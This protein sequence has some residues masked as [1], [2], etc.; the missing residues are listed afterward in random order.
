MGYSATCYSSTTINLDT[1][2]VRH[3]VA[4][5]GLYIYDA[6]LSRVPSKKSLQAGRFRSK[7]SL[8]S[9][10]YE[11]FKNMFSNCR[12]QVLQAAMHTKFCERFLTD[13]LS[14]RKK[15]YYVLVKMYFCLDSVAVEKYSTNDFIK[16][17]SI[18]SAYK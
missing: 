7:V 18:V 2:R 17:R 11:Q 14:K 16:C 5:E 10:W 6:A 8:Q 13:T 9:R 12:G 3:A 15:I 4:D 1:E